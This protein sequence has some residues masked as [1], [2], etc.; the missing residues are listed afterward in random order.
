MLQTVHR[1]YI[2]SLPE[3]SV[4]CDSFYWSYEEPPSISKKLL[5]NTQNL[6]YSHH[7]LALLPGSPLKIL[8]YPVL[9]FITVIKWPPLPYV[10]LIKEFGTWI[11]SFFSPI[12]VINSET[13]CP[14]GQSFPSDKTLLRSVFWT[15]SSSKI[16]FLI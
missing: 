4:S 6:D 10:T 14:D 3:L 15:S 9:I 2:F 5:S 1:I 11:I 12:P 13:Q 8:L 7:L 16:Y